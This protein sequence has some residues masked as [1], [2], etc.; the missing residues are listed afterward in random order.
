MVH[1]PSARFNPISTIFSI[2][3]PGEAIAEVGSKGYPRALEETLQQVQGERWK[4]DQSS[5]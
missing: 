3:Y 4:I 1:S 2:G 5:K